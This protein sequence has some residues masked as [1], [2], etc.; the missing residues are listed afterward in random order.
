MKIKIIE[1][2]Y[3]NDL[4]RIVKVD[5]VFDVTKDRSEVLIGKKYAEKENSYSANFDT[6][7][8]NTY[9]PAY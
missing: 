6:E 3:D 7:G 1:D 8:E 9:G 2:Y 5:E 4:K